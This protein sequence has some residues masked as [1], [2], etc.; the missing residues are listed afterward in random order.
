MLGISPPST[1]YFMNTLAM[2]VGPLV[3]H[4]TGIGGTTEPDSATALSIILGYMNVIALF[5]ATGW[6][7]Y[8]AFSGTLKT[9]HEGEWLGQKWSALLLPLRIAIAV[10]AV[11]PVIPSGGGTNYSAVQAAV[12]YAEANAVGMAD[13]A[14]DL[15]AQN[16][17]RNPIGGVFINPEK[18]HQ[19]ANVILVDEVCM[20]AA[21]HAIETSSLS[22]AGKVELYNT[23][24]GSIQEGVSGAWHGLENSY[25]EVTGG[26][27]HHAWGVAYSEYDWNLNGA[28]Y[29]SMIGIP[30]NVCGGISYPSSAFGGNTA[31][32]IDNAVWGPAS[33]QLGTLIS[34]IQP[35]ANAIAVHQQPSMAAFKAAMDTYNQDTTQAAIKGIAAVEKPEEAKFL[36]GVQTEGFATAGSWW[37]EMMH[38]NQV[39]QSAL[40]NIGT[41]TLFSDSAIANVI[42][43]GMMTRALKR[44]GD[45]EKTYNPAQADGTHRSAMPGQHGGMDW[46]M[47][48]LGSMGLYI[49]DE[50]RNKNPILGL[51]HVGTI[52]TTIGSA[53]LA[54]PAAMKVT[55][56][57]LDATA[58][59]QGGM[60][61]PN[62]AAALAATEASKMESQFGKWAML[63][64][65]MFFGFGLI[66][67]VWI[68]MLP[69][70]IWTF[71]IFSLL[72]FFV[73]ALFA[74]PFWAVAHMNPDGHEVVGGG[75]KGWMMILQVL[76]KPVLMV[77]G[78]VAGTAILYA[79]A[80][81]LQNTIGGAILDIFNNSAG[82]FEGPFDAMSEVVIYIIMLIVVVDMSFSL[83]HKLPDWVMAWI[84]GGGT[85]RGGDEMTKGTGKHV[86][87]GHDVAN[88]LISK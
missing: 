61:G 49:A 24:R 84:G 50:P 9:A 13:Y 7:L 12:I 31:A 11:L 72:I 62:D 76:L 33:T 32:N 55:K 26:V 30:V 74:A 5:V 23:P 34:S 54:G 86:E 83:I 27:T 51:E 28:H 3:N 57:V 45:F 29:A 88:K 17:V 15:A 20:D 39:A 59:L 4:V 10:A 80:W 1:D 40:N 8:I 82:G 42:T 71:A 47:N 79:G 48:V 66:L 21:N 87:L 36:Q 63:L 53:I 41:G 37:W 78:L 43:G 65:A 58:L 81:I 85:D 68:P 14:L 2:I 56:Y 6:I 35:I 44:A 22:I 67:T 75:G 18:T 19:M 73:E 60:D 16:I 38:M 52:F 25:Q 69:F 46:V 77:G 70:I 64:G